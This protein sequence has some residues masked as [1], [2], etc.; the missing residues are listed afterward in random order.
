MQIRSR[1]WVSTSASLVVSGVLAAYAFSVLS[2]IGDDLARGRKY[3]EVIE[4]A[5]AL[6]LLA[7][8]F[9][10]ETS[11]RATQQIRDVRENLSRLL[12]GLYS[13][14]IQEKALIGHL[15]KNN[16]ELAPLLDQLFRSMKEPD[17]GSP[18]EVAKML[19]S[20]VLVKLRFITDDTQR[21]MEISQA[22]IASAQS[23]GAYIVIVLMIAV[24][25]TKALLSFLSGRSILRDIRHLSN[26][27]RHISE[28]DLSYR[29]D[30]AGKNELTELGRA[31]NRMAADLQAS[32]LKLREYTLK[33]ERTNR[34]LQD[35]THIAS[36][37]L[38]EPLRKIQMFSKCVTDECSDGLSER[39]RDF[40]ARVVSSARRMQTL[41]AALLDYSRLSARR[42]PFA[43]V[44]LNLVFSEILDDLSAQLMESGGEVTVENLPCIEADP[45]Q[46]RQLFQNLVSNA[47]KYRRPEVPPRIRVQG[48]VCGDGCF[49]IAV[50]DNGIGFEEIYLDKI[51][52]PF[53]RLHGRNE[54]EGIGIGLATCR[55]I[56]D[57]H[58]GRIT[59]R[60]K[61]GEGAVFLVSLPSRQC[62]TDERTGVL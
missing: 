49:E 36:H 37:D 25:A 12:D 17:R 61:P 51:F 46:M 6:S 35:F 9:N 19:A 39:N 53:Q 14:D 16:G 26:G 55:R 8:S 43:S 10:Q 59:A 27:V 28:G 32:L 33:M 1:I 2:G 29:I 23:K 54:Y 31:F 4:K 38:Q 20:R 3:N 45:V 11:S 15:Q 7:S 18:A 58:N 22:R 34:E 24:I 57:S 42:A 41:I 48:S 62:E 13:T 50:S 30:M 52:T 21:L 56:V 5:F 47:L 44:D 60:S 40:L